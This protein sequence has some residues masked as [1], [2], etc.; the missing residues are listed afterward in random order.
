VHSLVWHHIEH[1][2][3]SSLVLFDVPGLL[4]LVTS[5]GALLLSINQVPEAFAAQKSLHLFAPG[6]IVVAIKRLNA[7]AL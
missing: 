5:G 6:S 4:L 3:A 7:M 2:L 1:Q